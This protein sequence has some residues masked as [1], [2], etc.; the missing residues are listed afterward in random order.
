MG[1]G[2]GKDCIGPEKGKCLNLWCSL[3]RDINIM[4]SSIE[5]MGGFLGG[6]KLL[7]RKEVG[8]SHNGES[9]DGTFRYRL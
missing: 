3:M 6:V 5:I 4:K 1:K 8:T 9:T 2:L 7:Q